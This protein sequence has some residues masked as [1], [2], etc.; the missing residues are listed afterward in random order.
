MEKFLLLLF[1]W[2]V[3]SFSFALLFVSILKTRKT[4]EEIMNIKVFIY[5]IS[6][7]LSAI[8]LNYIRDYLFYWAK[9][10]RTFLVS[11]FQ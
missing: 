5:S 7:I 8:L 2:A 1:T 6:G 11:L 9:L 3:L 10:L 4:W